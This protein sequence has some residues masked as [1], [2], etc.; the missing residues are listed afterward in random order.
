VQVPLIAHISISDV[1]HLFDVVA[2]SAR[3]EARR[4]L[5]VIPPGDP[6]YDRTRL[7]CP[8]PHPSGAL[9][10]SYGYLDTVDVVDRDAQGNKIRLGRSIF[11][12]ANITRASARSV[13]M[14]NQAQWGVDFTIDQAAAGAF[15]PVTSRLALLP[16]GD[17]RKEIAIV[18]DRTVIYR[19]EVVGALS[20]DIRIVGNL[21]EQ[22][23]KDL[24]T[25]L[26][27]GA[28]PIRLTRRSTTTL[29]SS[30]G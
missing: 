1:P 17:A 8:N 4:V 12:G 26:G 15:N 21:T 13:L 6:R 14:L 27:S 7:T 23:A 11:T 18:V 19:P 16:T 5:E 28:L 2:G 29:A 22:S 30:S 25:Q 20:S 24:A 9:S 3:L 10:C